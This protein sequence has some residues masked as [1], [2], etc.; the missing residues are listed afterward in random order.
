MVDV[1]TSMLDLLFYRKRKTA[2][3]HFSPKLKKRFV[4]LKHEGELKQCICMQKHFSMVWAFQIQHLYL[5]FTF[6][7][8]WG[9]CQG[10]VKP[11]FLGLV[12]WSSVSRGHHFPYKIQMF[13]VSFR[14]LFLKS[15]KQSIILCI[16]VGLVI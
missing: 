15:I 7:G 8:I 1:E 14:K 11:V 10:P 2:C 3:Q 13:S 16:W 9:L 12:A 5:Y 4:K 6:R